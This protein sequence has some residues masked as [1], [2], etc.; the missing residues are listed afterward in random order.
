MGIELPE[1]NGQ[2]ATS[3]IQQISPTTGNPRLGEETTGI[4]INRSKLKISKEHSRFCI[5]WQTIKTWWVNL[6]PKLVAVRI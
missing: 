3:P 4:S 1:Q 5:R 6:P 2:V